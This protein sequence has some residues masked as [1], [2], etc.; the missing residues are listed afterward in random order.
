MASAHTEM[1][2]IINQFDHSIKRLASLE[3][4]EWSVLWGHL[5]SMGDL[6]CQGRSDLREIIFMDGDSHYRAEMFLS[7]I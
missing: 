1:V 3:G 6:L 2:A 4:N 7:T 5:Q